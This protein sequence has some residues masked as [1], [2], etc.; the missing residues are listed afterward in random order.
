MTRKV[1]VTVRPA[2]V[3]YVEGRAYVEGQA[4]DVSAADAATLVAQ[5]VAERA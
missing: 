2:R 1:T 4:L 3:V 5:G